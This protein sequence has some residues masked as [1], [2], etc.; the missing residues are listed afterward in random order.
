METH[1][2]HA[3]GTLCRWGQTHTQTHISGGVRRGLAN[4]SVCIVGVQVLLKADRRAGQQGLV[5]IDDVTLK[6]GP[7]L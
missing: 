1:A 5:A 6:P 7:C 4:V 3:D 2:G